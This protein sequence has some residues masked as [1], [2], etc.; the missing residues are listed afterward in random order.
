MRRWFLFALIAV[1][2][3]TVGGGAVALASSTQPGR[4][5]HVLL[6]ASD[7]DPVPGER[8]SLRGQVIPSHPGDRI[9]LQRRDANGWKTVATPTV[10]ARSRFST[11]LT[12]STSGRVSFRA[13]LPAQPHESGSRSRPVALVAS[14]IHKVKHVVIIMQENRSFDHYFGTFP[15]ATGIPGLAGNLGKLPCVHDPR[16][17]GCDKPFHDAN[18]VNYGGPHST[19]DSD[20]DMACANRTKH[21]DCRMNGFVAR[22]EAGTGCTGTNPNCSPCTDKAANACIDAMGYHTDAD[23][24]N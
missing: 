16:N 12:L 6:A 5:V 13:A 3:V 21:L 15:G 18:D 2:A 8:V 24:P 23:I 9:L 7:A 4:S 1:V 14:E 17:G 10:S 11:S 19:L 22:A 20:K